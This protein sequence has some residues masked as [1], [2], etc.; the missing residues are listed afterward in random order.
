MASVEMRILQ[1][2]L[3]GKVFSF[4]RPECVLFGRARDAAICITDDPFV[5]RNHLLFEISPPFVY[6]SD[7]GSKNGFFLNDVQYSIHDRPNS[8]K[9][10]FLSDGEQIAVGKN[11]LLINILGSDEKGLFGSNKTS[12]KKIFPY[13]G[14]P[15][16]S[17]GF[18]MPDS[19]IGSYRI[20][21]EI[22]RGWMGAVYQAIDTRSGQT[23]AL[24]TMVPNVIFSKV[25]AELFLNE[26][27]RLQRVDHPSICKLLDFGRKENLFY[28]VQEYIDGLDLSRLLIHRDGKLNMEEAVPIMLEVLEGLSHGQLDGEFIH[29]NFTPRN[30]L[31]YGKG[32]WIR[33]KIADFGLF[34]ALEIAGLNQMILSGNYV[35]NPCYWPRE[36]ITFYDRVDFASEVFSVASIF[37]EMLTGCLVRDSLSELRRDF[38]KAGR[39]PGLSDYLQV[40]AHNKP[41]PI[42]QKNPEIPTQVAEI[43]DRALSEPIINRSQAT[44]GEELSQTRFPNLENFRMALLEALNSAGLTSKGS[45]PDLLGSEEALEEKSEVALLVLDLANSTHLVNIRGTNFFTEIVNSFNNLFRNHE[46]RTGLKFLKGTGDGFFAIY[47]KVDDALLVGRALLAEAAKNDVQIRIAMNWGSVTI[48]SDGDFLGREVHRLFRIEGLK[49]S[50]RV[51]KTQVIFPPHGR[52]LVTKAVVERTSSVFQNLGF[53]RLKGFEEPWEIFLFCDNTPRN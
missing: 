26:L 36:R 6:V 41:I 18:L 44:P 23:V 11:R 30:I 25:A 49:E 32:R 16:A 9:S 5:S 46:S 48:A 7:L 12:G 15:N 47:R 28:C 40:I 19:L 27:S 13:S 10:I 35:E 38:K 52:I 37:Y 17:M 2:E 33:G 3:K 14:I 4:T 21:S 8:P 31:T 50:D 43:L 51:S 22:G 39:I 53:F 45:K 29:R 34:R 24:K 20:G 1:G 42:R